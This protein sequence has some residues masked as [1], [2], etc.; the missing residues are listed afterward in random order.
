MVVLTVQRS[1]NQ[2]L[3][4]YVVTLIV[5]FVLS[6][7]LVSNLGIMGASLLYTISSGVMV[8]IFS[9][10]VVFEKIKSEKLKG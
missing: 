1:Q 9:I 4:G 7:P 2:L 3:V 8:I 10:L 6:T 5:S